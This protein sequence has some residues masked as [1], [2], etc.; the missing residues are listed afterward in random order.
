MLIVLPFV[1]RALEPV[2]VSLVVSR[3]AAVVVP[4]VGERS[5]EDAGPCAGF[6]PLI[7]NHYGK[8]EDISH[9]NKRDVRYLVRLSPGHNYLEAFFH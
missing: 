6:L 4:S 1:K 3:P 7:V 9:R 2:L 8:C 5:K